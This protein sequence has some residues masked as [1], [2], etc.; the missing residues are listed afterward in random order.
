M[1]TKKHDQEFIILTGLPGSGKT[2]K[3]YEIMKDRD[4]F[5]RIDVKQFLSM[6]HFMATIDNEHE[7]FN[8][9][10]LANLANFVL[11]EKK[12]VI[13]DYYN[14]NPKEILFWRSIANKAGLKP[15]FVDLRPPLNKCIFNDAW[16]E[17]DSVGF[18]IIN[19]EAL[20]YG[21]YDGKFAQFIL[22]DIDGSILKTPHKGKFTFENILAHEFSEQK[23]NRTDIGEKK[24]IFVTK[25]SIK[26]R[27]ATFEW[28]NKAGLL[29]GEIGFTPVTILFKEDSIKEIMN[30]REYRYMKPLKTIK[31]KK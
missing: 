20:K 29:V 23:L 10:L 9:R 22:I 7:V 27:E 14:L 28:L 2:T 26:F 16:R 25:R 6:I 5:V 24:V 8:K 15:Q 1:K 11:K 3:A 12:S 17:T 13:I 4:D 21:L 19:K 30:G 31:G 18:D